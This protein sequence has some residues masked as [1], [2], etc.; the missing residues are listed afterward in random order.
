MIRAHSQEKPGFCEPIGPEEGAGVV[1]SVRVQPRSSRNEVVG[2]YN[3]AIKIKVKSPPVEGAAND[4]LIAYLSK[5][6][7]RPK[8][9][10]TIFSGHRSKEKRLR[11]DGISVQEVER[12]LF[13]Q[14]PV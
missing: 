2:E 1:L 11:I 4:A 3:G 13:K 7:K 10:I 6:L 8:S 12:A 9:S 14:A 5:L